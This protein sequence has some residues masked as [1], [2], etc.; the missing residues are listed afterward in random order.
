[1]NY[2]KALKEIKNVPELRSEFELFSK[3]QFRNLDVLVWH[4]VHNDRSFTRGFCE[5]CQKP[6][7][8][9]NFKWGYKRFCSKICANRGNT[10]SRIKTTQKRY[11][12]K[13]SLQ[14]PEI[15][16]KAKET[17]KEKYGSENFAQTDLFK[18]VIKERALERW[19]ME[20]H[21]HHPENKRR[22]ERGVQTKWGKRNVVHHPLIREKIKRT[23]IERYGVENPNQI[24]LDPELVEY[25]HSKKWWTDIYINDGLSIKEIMEETGLSYSYIW[26]KL[27]YFELLGR[28][29]NGESR[30]DPDSDLFKPIF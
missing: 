3:D 7:Q 13:S 30:E 18:E 17:L 29:Q 22:I 25:L 24:H 12:V 28:D 10:Q 1:M 9:V 16:A 8:F 6:T 2:K 14:H 23:L 20:H 27:K 26:E 15:K 4:F 11:G 5:Y 19:G 21:N